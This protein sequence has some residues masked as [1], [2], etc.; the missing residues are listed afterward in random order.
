MSRAG[1]PRLARRTLAALV[2]GLALAGCGAQ[3]SGEVPVST[4]TEAQR[5]SAIAR[6]ELPGSATVGRALTLSGRQSARIARLDTL[7]Q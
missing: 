2:T 6:G 5:D 1:E 4:L 3:V 7:P